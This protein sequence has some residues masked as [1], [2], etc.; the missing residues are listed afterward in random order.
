MIPQKRS[1]GRPARWLLL[2]QQLPTRPS[3]ARVK[4][5]RRLQ[6]L[7]AVP[8]KNSV[9]VLPNS[10]ETR[11]DL[12]WVKSEI[13]A[14]KGE[15]TLFEADGFDSLSEEEI[16]AAFRRARGEDYAALAR[17]TA[18]LAKAARA[19]KGDRRGS[20][21]RLKLLRK[22]FS[23]ISA[24]D[25]FGADGRDAVSR[26]LDEI[27]SAL[28]GTTSPVPGGRLD[29][30][31]FRG[32]LWVTRPR[33]GIDRMA[34]AWLVRRFIDPD[35][36][37]GFAEKLDAPADVVPFDMYGVELGHQADRCTM[38]TLVERFAVRNDSV[39]AV[40]RIVHHVDL[41][42]DGSASSEAAVMRALVAG[43]RQTYRE[44]G[45]LLERGIALFEALYRGFAAEER[46]A[47][48]RPRR[49]K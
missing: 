21:R 11:E 42:D 34:S 48:R 44:D 32:R 27:E 35:A 2:V 33:P 9:Y 18:K 20:A 8:V 25:F 7:G 30:R 45:E 37:F 41:K 19:E 3:N 29:P 23:E 36:R 38:E 10:P 1:R 15:A 31:D 5:W 14:M 17:E 16:V 24:I 4:T 6:A 13:V 47:K 46:P 43:L 26:R 49:K 39:D 40:A 28:E 12:E 22:R